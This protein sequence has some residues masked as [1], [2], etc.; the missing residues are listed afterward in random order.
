ME[1]PDSLRYR[2][3]LFRSNGRVTFSDRELFVESN[4]LSILTGQMIW[5]RRYDPLVDV[6]DVAEIRQR[7]QRVKMLIEQTAA[8]MPTHEDFI[9]KNCR[10]APL[11]PAQ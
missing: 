7:L 2:I 8:A 11:V 10:A 1:I 9:A 4:W 3:E 6:T 5:P